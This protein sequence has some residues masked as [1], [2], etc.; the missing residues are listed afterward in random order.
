MSYQYDYSQAQERQPTSTRSKPVNSGNE[1]PA[2]DAASMG[3]VRRN[4][5][6]GWW[7]K[8]TAPAWPSTPVTIEERERLRKAELT[9]FSLLAAFAFIVA[10]VSNSLADLTTAQAVGLLTIL[11]VIAAILN[12]TNRTRI[13]AYFVPSAMLLIL[14]LAIVQSPDGLRLI[15]LPIYDLCVIPVVLVSLTGDRQAP[16]LFAFLSI[17]FI[18][19]TFTLEHHEVLALGHG[20][21]FDGIGYETNIFGFWGMVNRHV[22]LIF[23][24][25]LFGWMGAIS[26]DHAIARADRAEEVARLQLIILQQKEQLEQGIQAIQQTQVRVANGDYKARAPLAEDHML[27]Q[28]AHSLNTMIQRLER[29]AK[30]EETIQRTKE[31]VIRLAHEVRQAK[32][33][34]RPHWPQPSGGLLDPL[35]KE[36]AS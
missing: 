1:P 31:D 24:A 35:I 5:L 18:L 33:G 8:M 20:V 3:I 29:A 2:Q 30:A 4:G 11:L 22:A 7:L 17:A 32:A 13:A 16:W 23:F 19:L 6:V 10:L 27:W 14:V 26:V 25:A 12:R 15:G 28:I 9:S 36:V 34:Q 21:T